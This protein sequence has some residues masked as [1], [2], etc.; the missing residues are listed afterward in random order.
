[1]GDAW[2][3]EVKMGRIMTINHTRIPTCTARLE[4]GAA[5]VERCC[6]RIDPP[7]SARLVT[8][9]A[10]AFIGMRAIARLAA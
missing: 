5:S 1:M 6:S 2:A 7:S 9:C 8:E 4:R 3:T 10:S